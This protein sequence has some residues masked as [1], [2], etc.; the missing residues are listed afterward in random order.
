L[1]GRV[2]AWIGK[3][4][5]WTGFDVL[6]DTTSWI[7]SGEVRGDESGSVSERGKDVKRM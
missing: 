6:V 1:C 5:S 4:R 3:E 7:E 2:E